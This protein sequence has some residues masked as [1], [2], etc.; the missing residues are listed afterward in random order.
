MR[1]P[2]TVAVMALLWGCTGRRLTDARLLEY[3][4]APY[5]KRAM[6]GKHLSLGL[7][8]GVPVLVD[9]PCGDLC[10]TYTVRVIH[11]DLPTGPECA[12][13]GGV[14]KS[15]GVWLGPGQMETPFCFPK[16]LTDHWAS[17]RE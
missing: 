14:V 16:V 15:M 12:A 17:Y 2:A 11:Y 1:L 3:A 9:F 6:E 10:P 8:N 4:A 7:H 5:D 13:R